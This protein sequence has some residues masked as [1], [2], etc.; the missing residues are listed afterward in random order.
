[1]NQLKFDIY[2]KNALCNILDVDVL[3]KWDLKF[4]QYIH[5]SAHSSHICPR[6][7]QR[8]IFMKL[9]YAHEHNTCYNYDTGTK[10]IIEKIILYKNQVL[11]LKVSEYKIIVVKQGSA[12]LDNMERKLEVGN[13]WFAE[14]QA[15]K[16]EACENSIIIIFR[17]RFRIQLCERFLLDKLFRNTE[18]AVSDNADTRYLKANRITLFYIE[19]LD[20]ILDTGLKCTNFLEVKIKELFYF[21]R[22]YY[23]KEELSGFFSPLANRDEVF[24]EFVYKNYKKAKNTIELARIANYSVSGFEK[25]FKDTFG[26]SAGKWMKKQKATDIF[27]EINCSDKSLKEISFDYGFYSPSHL[28]EY[29]KHYFG[30][31][32]G[33]LREIRI[34][35]KV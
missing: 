16:L 34:K 14:P 6:N 17:M 28:N 13:M 26:I 4:R 23:T 12:T 35:R 1:M 29:C 24:A 2:T 15:V 7:A 18:M 8:Q 33:K 20:Q 30:Q 19:S 22:A 3:R 10:P 27:H 32:P 9:L 5:L 31:T 11:E 21:L 25:R